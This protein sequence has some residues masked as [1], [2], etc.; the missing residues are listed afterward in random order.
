[1]VICHGRQLDVPIDRP[2]GRRYHSYF[3]GGGG[4]GIRREFGTLRHHSV[5]RVQV[6]FTASQIA[7]PGVAVGK[8]K[9]NSSD[10]SDEGA[11]KN[12]AF[13][14]EFPSNCPPATARAIEGVFYVGHRYSPPGPDDLKTAAQNK[15]FQDKCEC[16]RRSYSVMKDLSDVRSLLELYPKRYRY[17]S[18]GTIK[19]HHGVCL[20]TESR[21]H[22]SHH[23]F[24]RYESVSITDI[25]CESI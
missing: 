13:R 15:R 10:G 19:E 21:N 16:E 6:P 5:I 11:P 2:M 25:F 9:T 8:L 4:I 20:S 3:C 12:Y 22:K 23:S 17:I 24:W 14:D 7:P 18:R 1:M